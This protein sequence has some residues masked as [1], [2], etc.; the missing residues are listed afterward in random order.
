MGEEHCYSLLRAFCPWFLFNLQAGPKKVSIPLY[1]WAGAWGGNDRGPLLQHVSFA[2]VT[3]QSAPGS[4]FRL[5]LGLGVVGN[6]PPDEWRM[7]EHLR[8]CDS[9][10]WPWASSRGFTVVSGGPPYLCSQRPL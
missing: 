1:I 2:W 9:V 5:G 7:A 3:R 6:Q 4:K 8:I 10:A